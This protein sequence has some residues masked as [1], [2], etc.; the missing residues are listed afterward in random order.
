MDHSCTSK[1]QIAY[2]LR[3]LHY[4]ISPKFERCTGISQSRLELL[5]HLYD[6]EEISQTTLQ[7]VVHIDNAAVTRHLKQLEASGMVNRRKNPQDN[8][9]TLVSL[10]KQ[11]RSKILSY[12]KE[13]D[14]FVTNL[15][16]GFTEKELPV[17]VDMLQRMQQNA[18]QIEG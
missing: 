12:R 5:Q 15:L 2:I 17:L 14:Q 6:A 1:A 11:G 18:E 10:T 13:K 16:Q 7:K 4:Q 9:V 3:E 8:R